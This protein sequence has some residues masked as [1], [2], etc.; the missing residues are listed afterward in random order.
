MDVT[1]CFV[2]VLLS[3]S[4]GLLLRFFLVLL[5]VGYKQWLYRYVQFVWGDHFWH[6]EAGLL[7]PPEHLIL[8][9]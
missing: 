8:R 6:R 1:E 2:G 5:F 4:A 3:L 7:G 9:S